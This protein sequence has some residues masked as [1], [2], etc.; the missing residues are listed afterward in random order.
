MTPTP[1][2]IRSLYQSLLTTSNRF[3]SYNFKN[4]FVRRTNESF[5]PIL[6]S[7]DS[8][9]PV[10]GGIDLSQFYSDQSKELEV[11]R[12]AAEVNRLYEGPKLVVEH[13]R[14]ITSE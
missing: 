9:T 11:L 5:K 13:A 6:K 3:A 14:P 2:Q 4:Y 10:A 8:S 12:R 1:A 7:L